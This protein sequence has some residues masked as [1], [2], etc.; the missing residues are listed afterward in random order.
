MRPW[1]SPDQRSERCNGVA[2]FATAVNKTVWGLNETVVISL[3]RGQ[4]G[5]VVQYD[6]TVALP[7]TVSSIILYKIR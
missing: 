2:G 5:T 4:R 3:I 6:S 1:L 7:G